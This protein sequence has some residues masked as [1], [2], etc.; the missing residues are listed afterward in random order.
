MYNEKVMVDLEIIVFIYLLK[1]FLSSLLLKC[2]WIVRN[3]ETYYFFFVLLLS[4]ESL[5]HGNILA[6]LN[7]LIG[8]L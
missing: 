5:I 8:K 3:V 4:S 1:K 6:D 2:K 7:T